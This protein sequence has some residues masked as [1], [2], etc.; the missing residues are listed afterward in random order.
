MREWANKY[1]LKQQNH[2]L[3]LIIIDYTSTKL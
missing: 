2:A 3:H 1:V